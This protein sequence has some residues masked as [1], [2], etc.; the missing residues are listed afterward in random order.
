MIAFIDIIKRF[1]SDFLSTYGAMLLPSQKKALA[2]INK[3]RTAMSA[4]MQVRCDVC[5][6]IEYL[7]HSRGHRSCFCLAPILR[8]AFAIPIPKPKK[9]KPEPSQAS[10]FYVWCYSTSYRRDFDVRAIL[11]FCIPIASGKL[12]CC[13]FC[14]ECS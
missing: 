14:C 5:L 2:A 4:K 7:P 13:K 12:R 6:E 9:Q 8:S 10:S 1:E 3:C 11:V